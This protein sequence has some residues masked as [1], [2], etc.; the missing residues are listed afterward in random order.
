MSLISR[1]ENKARRNVTQAN[2][3][4][5]FSPDFLTALVRQQDEQPEDARG[6]GGYVHVTALLDFCQRRWSLIAKEIDNRPS[7]PKSADRVMWAIGRALEHHVRTQIIASVGRQSV[8]GLWKCPCG[9]LEVLGLGNSSSCNSCKREASIFH[10]VPVFD[11]ELK[12]TG[13]PDL[14]LLH[15]SQGFRV[16]EIKSMNKKDFDLLQAP[17]PN[18]VF[19]VNSYRKMMLATGAV[20]CAEA[21]ILYVAKDY[22]FKSPYKEFHVM[23]D[24]Q[25]L[26][27]DAMF[28]QVRQL[29]ATDERGQLPAKLAVCA[30]VD[31]PFARRC[32]QA[33]S[34][35]SR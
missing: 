8:Y 35:F 24:D 11:H 22:S 15:G 14:V 29:R 25:M 12:I 34:C 7:L 1:L 20:V 6:V 23:P 17:V 32:P 28:E 5:S 33:V 26:T 19:Q 18:H 3:L 31:S 21:I 4:P 9:G 13:S 16:V 30:S 2:A 27:I 10:E